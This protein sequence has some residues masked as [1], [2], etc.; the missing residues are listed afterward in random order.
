[1]AMKKPPQPLELEQAYEQASPTL[2][3]RCGG[4][5]VRGDFSSVAN[6]GVT[7]E[8]HF[9]TSYGWMQ[10]KYDR[11]T[12]V[13]AYMCLKCG[14]VEFYGRDPLAVLDPLERQQLLRSQNP[15]LEKKLSREEKRRKEQEKK[16]LPLE[17]DEHKGL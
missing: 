3:A 15:E 7:R 9:V 12:P 1:M 2:C 6:F 16:G 17:G 14:H 10:V 4:Q 8:P 13:D 11:A 5:C